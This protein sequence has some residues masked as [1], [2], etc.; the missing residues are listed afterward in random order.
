MVHYMQKVKT[1]YGLS[2]YC[3]AHRVPYDEVCRVT[4]WLCADGEMPQPRYFKKFEVTSA[5][6]P[7]GYRRGSRRGVL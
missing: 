3:Q 6:V 1:E 7:I 2:Y 5:G 4:S